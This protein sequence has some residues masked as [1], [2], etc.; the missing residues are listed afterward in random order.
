MS[1]RENIRL[2]A[3]AP[4]I[5]KSSADNKKA[6]TIFPACKML[7]R[8]QAPRSEC[9]TDNYYP[10]AFLKKRRGY[11]NRLRPS[12]R[13]SVMLSPPKPLEEIQ[14]NLVCELLT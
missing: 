13:L 14:P 2:I 11:C 3:R 7:C 5:L 8:Y 12:V 1:T 6:C 4:L 9:V 10:H